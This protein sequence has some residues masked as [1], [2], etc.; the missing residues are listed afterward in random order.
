MQEELTDRGDRSHPP[1]STTSHNGRWIVCMAVMD[2]TA[3]SRTIAQRI[4]FVTHH[5]VSI[6]TIRCCL[7]QSGMS[8]RRPSLRLPVTG[9]HRCLRRQW[10]DEWRTWTMEWNHIVFTDE[11]RVCLQHHDDWIRV[12]R[13]RGERLLN[14][15]VM[16]R[17][18]PGIMVWGGI[19]FHRH[20]PLVCIT[21]TLN[22]SQPY[23]SEVLKPMVLPYIQRL[24][25]YSN[26]IM[27]DHTQCSRVLYPSD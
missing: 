17:P 13:H 7:Q 5:S 24:P 25:S 2:R 21:G 12:W 23:I 19:G 9:N 3:T 1:R 20:T 26:R 8:A 10:C 15:C 4:Q 27:H 16:H 22:S 6:R 18:A 14:F 11:S